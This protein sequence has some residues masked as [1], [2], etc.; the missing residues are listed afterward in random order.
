MLSFSVPIN[1][2]IVPNDGHL[3]RHTRHKSHTQSHHGLS[4]LRSPMYQHDWSSFQPYRI[5]S[6][7]RRSLS[8]KISSIMAASR[9]FK[10]S[11]PETMRDHRLRPCAV[12]GRL[13]SLSKAGTSTRMKPT[14]YTCRND[15]EL[16]LSSCHTVSANRRRFQPPRC[17][18]DTET[19]RLSKSR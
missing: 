5:S 11:T 16:K 4:T 8:P 14:L 15:T 13:A 10:D 6:I 2:C 9:R 3:Y 17:S 12:G 1:Y 18:Q 7:S 19:W